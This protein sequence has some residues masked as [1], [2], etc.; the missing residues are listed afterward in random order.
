MDAYRTRVR[1]KNE[2]KARLATEI[3]LVLDNT[4]IK[5]RENWVEECSFVGETRGE[6]RGWVREW[7]QL[8]SES[9]LCRAE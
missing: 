4:R 7:G 9:R 8:M 3:S 6:E 2:G 5:S 1:V